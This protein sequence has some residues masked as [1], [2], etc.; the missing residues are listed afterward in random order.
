M[1]KIIANNYTPKRIFMGKMPYGQ[2]IL[3]SIEDFCDSMSI[4]VGYFSLIG[5]VS[6][7]TL[8]YYDQKNK[9]YMTYK[10]NESLEIVSCNGNISLK[11]DKV[12][13]HSHGVFSDKQGDVIA[14]HIFSDSIIFAGEIYIQELEGKV[15]KRN[16]DDTTALMLWSV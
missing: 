11:D 9:K 5:A 12:F 14:G 6:S 2:D 10:K 3:K 13:V 8:G 7:L 16:F 15:L 1:N 4:N